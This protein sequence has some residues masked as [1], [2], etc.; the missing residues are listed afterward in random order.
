MIRPVLLAMFVAVGFAWPAQAEVRPYTPF[1]VKPL[2]ALHGGDYLDCWLCDLVGVRNIQGGELTGN[3]DDL[4]LDIGAGS[5]ENPGNVNVNWDVGD[6]FF[7]WSGTKEPL[8]G[9]TDLGVT[10]HR[11]LLVCDGFGC[12]DVASRVRALDSRVQ[13]LTRRV[14]VLR[15]ALR[16]SR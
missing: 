8:L 10:A 7:V 12:V 15:R 9:A 4:N 1:N 5:T 14:R 13:R 11:R 6:D 3:P 2:L 16:S